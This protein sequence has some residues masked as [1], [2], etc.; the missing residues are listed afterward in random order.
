MHLFSAVDD[1]LKRIAGAESYLALPPQERERVVFTAFERLSLH[2][3]ERLLVPKIVA[4]QA[5]YMT[6]GASVEGDEAVAL[7]N[8]RK[9]GAKSYSIDGVSVSFD[10]SK[11]GS[12]IAPD[13]IA[14]FDVQE[15]QNKGRARV[16]RLI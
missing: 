2:Y 12:G 8:L 3:A 11:G 10:D 4:L 9:A 16:G 13:V 5:I 7:Q 6:D 14:Y 15:R 1:Y